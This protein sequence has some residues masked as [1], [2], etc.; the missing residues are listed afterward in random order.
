[1]K[2]FLTIGAGILMIAVA[3]VPFVNAS[4]DAYHA[5]V[6][7][8]PCFG[9]TCLPASMRYSERNI[10]QFQ[11]KNDG[12]PAIYTQDAYTSFERPYRP[13]TYTRG[14]IGHRYRYFRTNTYRRGELR[15]GRINEDFNLKTYTDAGFSLQLP[16]GAIRNQN[17][18]YVVYDVAPALRVAIRKYD[19]SICSD[20][21]GF[22]ACGVKIS[23][24]ENRLA[25]FGNADAITTSQIIRNTQ[26]SDTVLDTQIQTRTFNESFSAYMNHGE[27]IY[28]SRYIVADVD[29]GIYMVETQTPVDMASQNIGLTKRIFDSFRIYPY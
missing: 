26:F 8:Y 16:Q 13:T 4:R 22:F 7:N 21:Q 24:N 9:K 14:R 18:D 17:E 1:M 3:I 12:S 11:L 29:G 25:T 28:I 23:K 15:F 27:E 2:K 6:H 20:S 10:Q 5:V 19:P